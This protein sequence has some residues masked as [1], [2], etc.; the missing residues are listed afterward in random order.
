MCKTTKNCI[1]TKKYKSDII[2]LYRRGNT[3]LHKRLMQ[4][5]NAYASTYILPH[6]KQK[7]E[8]KNEF[9]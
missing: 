3:N 6:K 4:V 7:E 5:L 9:R 1:L 8:M 2:I